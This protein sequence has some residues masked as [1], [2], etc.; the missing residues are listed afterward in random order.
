ME[1]SHVDTTAIPQKLPIRR[2]NQKVTGSFEEL[3]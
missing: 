3:L 1:V 2:E